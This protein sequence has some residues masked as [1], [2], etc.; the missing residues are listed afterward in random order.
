M[1][2]SL[3]P[4][5][6]VGNTQPRRQTL[7]EVA[8]HQLSYLSRQSTPSD[9]VPGTSRVNFAYLEEARSLKYA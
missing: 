3:Q 8:G 6:K 2:T 7:A 4:K 9:H 1:I 5:R